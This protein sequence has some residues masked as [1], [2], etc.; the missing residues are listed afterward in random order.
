MRMLIISVGSRPENFA[1]SSTLRAVATV[2]GHTPSV[3]TKIRPCTPMSVA[4][5]VPTT[6]VSVFDSTL[7]VTF[8]VERVGTMSS[9]SAQ[10]CATV[11]TGN[12]ASRT[13]KS[14]PSGLH[15]VTNILIKDHN[16][17]CFH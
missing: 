10:L 5:G 6:K 16:M 2:V 4:P 13:A 15:V 3:N 8:H 14:S 17:P 9:A 1:P 7:V 12:I 11:V